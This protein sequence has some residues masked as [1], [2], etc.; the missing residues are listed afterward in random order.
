[1]VWAYSTHIID[2][3]LTKLIIYKQVYFSYYIEDTFE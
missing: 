2:N 3:N 1:M